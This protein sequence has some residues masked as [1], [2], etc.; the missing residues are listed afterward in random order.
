[1]TRPRRPGRLD[2]DLR[3]ELEHHVAATIDYLTERG[4]PAEEAREEAFRR[5]GSMDE[6]HRRLY[7]YARDRERRMR[8]RDWLQGVVQDLRYAGRALRRE[9]AFATVMVATLA[10]AIGVNAAMFGIVDRLLLRGPDHVRAPDRVMR[11]YYTTTARPGSTI[12]TFSAN[13]YAAYAGYRDGTSRFDA[14]AAYGNAHEMHLGEGEDA[15]RVKVNLATWTMFPL[16]GVTPAVGRFFGAAEDTPPAGEAVA[17]LGHGLWTRRFGADPSVVGRD[18]VLQGSRHTVVGVTP[19][20]FTGPELE[21]VDVWVP[22]SHRNAPRPDW[23]ETWNA[24]WLHVIGRLGPG[25]SPEEASADAAAAY[26]RA[27]TGPIDWEREHAV[28]VRPLRYDAAGAERMEATVSRWLAG[29]AMVVLLVGC[30]NII[31]LLLARGLRRRREIAMRAALGISRARLVRLLAAE[32]ALL[33]AAGAAAA[34]AVAWVTGGIMRAELLP[35]VAWTGPPVDARLLVFTAAATLVTMLLVGLAPA[36][37]AWR[38][39]LTES[40]KDGAPQAGASRSWLRPTLTIAQTAL[41]VVL[42]VGAGLFVESLDR[43][44]TLDLG[45]EP[46]R[47]LIASLQWRPV[48]AVPDDERAAETARRRAMTDWTLPRLRSLPQVESASAAIGLPFDSAFGIELRV[49]GVDELPRLPGGGPYVSAVAPDYFETVGTDVVAGRM[50]THADGAG[51]EPVAIVNETMARV[52]WPGEPALDKCL[53]IGGDRPCSRVVGVAEDTRRFQL[54]EEPAMQYYVPMGQERQISGVTL[55]VRPSGPPATMADAIRRELFA[56]DPTLAYVNVSVLQ[57]RLD[58][59][60]RPWQLGTAVFAG[61]GGL[62]LAI[63]VIGLYSVMAYATSQRTREVGIR[64]A[65]GAQRRDVLGLVMSGGLAM[66]ALGIGLGALL[67]LAG[68]PWLEPLLFDTSPHSPEV[69]ALVVVTLLFTAF[70]ASVIPARRA[71]RVDPAVTL[72]T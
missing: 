39:R 45:I 61:F 29:V 68:A 3:L 1:M 8:I 69:F 63:A 70:V 53:Q 47:V 4:L 36:A 26:R 54:R 37:Q 60:M 38:I 17:V 24:K 6:A 72:R 48:G 30:A 51:T 59:Q 62:A 46:D 65:L 55:L 58:P 66:A 56:L 23:P 11:V 49:P 57:D 15:E 31:N 21:P 5:L 34:L 67:A 41:S 25:V 52:L 40:L 50:F 44:R 64:M 18:I 43:V 27:Y 42:L 35:E 16:L 12:S 14:F 7:P 19:R 28:T 2:R 20:G 32:L 13:G 9:P 10:L 22:V 71:T 33:G